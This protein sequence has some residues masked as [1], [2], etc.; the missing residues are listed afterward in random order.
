MMRVP[1]VSMRKAAWPYQVI[2]MGVWVWRSG[3][4]GSAGGSWIQDA[5][6]KENQVSSIRQPASNT[7]Q[8]NHELKSIGARSSYSL[9]QGEVFV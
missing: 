8:G 1:L 9:S 5:A 7:V 6:G 2:F 4:A 3:R